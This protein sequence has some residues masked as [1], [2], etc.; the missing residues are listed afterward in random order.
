MPSLRIATWNI[1]SVRLRRPLL[2]ELV[3]ALDP[4]VLCL[5]ETKCPDELLPVEGLRALGYPHVAARGM[6]G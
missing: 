5:Q 4:D 6:K 2:A 1:N 3:K